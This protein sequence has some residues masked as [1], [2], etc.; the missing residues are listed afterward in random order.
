MNLARVRVLALNDLRLVLRDRMLAVLLLAAFGMG[1]GGRHA[2]PAIDASLAA[3]GVMPASPGGMRFAETYPLFVAFIA[4]WQAALMP[5]TVFGFLLLDEKED[6]TLT[7]M[8][9]TPVPLSTYLVYRAGIP[10][11]FAFLFSLALVPLIGLGPLPWWQH[12]PLAFS[13]ALVAPIVALMLA[14]FAA[15]KVQ[16][17]ALTKFGGVAGLLILVGFFVPLPYQWALGLFPPFLTAR[18]YWWAQAGH[19]HWWAPC[20]VAILVQLAILRVVVRRFRRVAF[21]DAA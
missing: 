21:N 5:G 18:A 6:D 14:M 2:L 1:L 15:D 7:A 4:F 19:P 3:S 8:R 13:A 16:G 9:V 17:L 20:V 11:A 10:T 12:L